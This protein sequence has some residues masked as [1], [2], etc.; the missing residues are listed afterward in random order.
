MQILN[1][2]LGGDLHA[3]LPDVV[4]EAVTHRASQTEAAVASGAPR[5]RHARSPEQLGARARSRG[6]P[7]WHHQ[8]LGRLGAGPAPGRLG[9]G[10][11]D[12]GGRAAPA[13]RQ[14]IAVQWHPE[15]AGAARRG[16]RPVR[17]P[18]RR[19]ARELRPQRAL[20]S[21]AVRGSGA[22]GGPPIRSPGASGASGARGG[23]SPADD[24]AS[25]HHV[26]A[27]RRLPPRV[28]PQH[29]EGR[30]LRARRAAV[31]SCAKWSRSRSCFAFCEQRRTLEAEVVHVALRRRA[32]ARP[33]P[34]SRRRSCATSS[35]ACSRARA[36]RRTAPGRL[37]APSSTAATV[38]RREAAA[39]ISTRI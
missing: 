31:S 33:V 36:A 3:H 38:G 17:R 15:L 19:G 20:S 22:G 26:R 6:V 12:R 16:S 37:A 39:G 13:Q 9:A 7:S 11:R 2:A 29:R 23:I 10:R 24:P 28:R 5:A 4:G 34:A 1:V 18:G 32:S 14:L 30:R 27:S 21:R 8:A 25:S 35:R